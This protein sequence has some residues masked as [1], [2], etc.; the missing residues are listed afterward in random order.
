MSSRSRKST[1]TSTVKETTS[2]AGSTPAG[3]ST[4]QRQSPSSGSRSRPPSP[5][6]ISRLQEKKELAGLNDRLASYID[7]V[8][9]LEVENRQLTTRVQTQEET[10]T[11]EVTNIKILYEQELSDARKLLDETSKEKARLQ[12]EV[13]KYKSEAE[14]FKDKYTKSYR[15]NQNLEKKLLA[16][17][18]QVND[19]QARLND[20]INQRKHWEN[21][22]HKVKGELSMLEKQLST[23]KKQLEEET[24]ARV[25]LEN[26]L[27]SLKE[28]LAFKG[29]VHE[30]EL[31]ETRTRT[32]THLEE[33]DGVLQQ[34]YENKV[35]AALQ[36]MREENEYNMRVTREETEN[37]F[38]SKLDDLK[39][40]A[41]E[42]DGT[43]S[44]AIE[45]MKTI[46]RRVDVLASENTKLRSMVATYEARISELEKQLG[47][48]QEENEAA[49]S[50]RDTE[51]RN[52]RE[53][54]EHQL[55]EY[56]DLMDIKIALDMEIAAY[57]KLLESEET[58][59]NISSASEATPGGGTPRRF[60]TTSGRK[61]KRGLAME[62]ASTSALGASMFSSS[63]SADFTS[64][65]SQKGSIEINE[66]DA[67]GK[68]IKLFNTS[69]KDQSLGSWQLK[70]TAG[71]QETV[72]KFHRSLHMKPGAYATVWSSDS[73]TT[74][75]PPTDLV[76]KGQRWFTADN[77][78]STLM[79]NK[80]KEMASREMKKSQ[81]R[82]TF[83]RSRM[84]S[85]ETDSG[86][87][88]DPRES[89]KC[90]IM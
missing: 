27:Q 48:E 18:A 30:Q 79:D 63:S 64:S 40:I 44:N 17:E 80:G 31:N 85:D 3:A 54:L 87:E 81:L 36:E 45:E 46:R 78:T 37:V 9:S 25:D 19:L 20:A 14:E 53:T 42:K 89:E 43:A 28:E 6:M 90:V 8:R 60:A 75:S 74:H 71:E 70:H 47:R 5:T 68:F 4:S 16:A 67:E 73:E 66:T 35:G 61:R 77:M 58:R 82:T 84:S 49:I 32:E 2:A 22:Y 15:D 55:V 83:Q 24:V 34:E 23:A 7:R 86:I 62:E 52:L 88:G 29:Q 56:R 59:L 57:R 65:S 12:I 41:A 21:E 10:T 72:F 39:R 26:R 13:G 69:D 76:M 38:M 50:R 51:I 33:V 11:R 1:T